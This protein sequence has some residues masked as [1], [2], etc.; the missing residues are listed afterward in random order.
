MKINFNKNELIDILYLKLFY[1]NQKLKNNFD[2]TYK[3]TNK[4]T[5]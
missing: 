1:D 3:I 4:G 2:T 5:N